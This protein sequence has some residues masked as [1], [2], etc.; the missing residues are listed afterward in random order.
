MPFRQHQ[1]PVP[2]HDWY[3][4]R[5][6][7]D[8][9][10]DGSLPCGMPSTTKEAVTKSAAPTDLEIKDAVLIFNRVWRQLEE[11]YGR[12]KLRFPKELILLGGA[13]GAGKGTNSDFIREVRG[14]TAEPVVI[15][16]LLST[17]EAQA[18]KARGG[19]V[20]DSEVIGAAFPQ[21]ARAGAAER[22]DPRRVSADE[23]AGG[24]PEDALR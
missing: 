3:D 14:I 22:R 18:I 9:L 1:S 13:P 2:G 17:P 12:A 20:G 11:E 16:E 7:L 4:Q 10:V 6:S 21:A 23:G 15:S 24:V 19:M 8:E 5:M